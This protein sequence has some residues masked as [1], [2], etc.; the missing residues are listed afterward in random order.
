[1]LIHLRL[2]SSLLDFLDSLGLSVLTSTTS[3]KTKLLFFNK[4]DL[5]AA[6]DYWKF[7]NP[8]KV[9]RVQI[10]FVDSAE[11]VG[12]VRSIAGNSPSLLARTSAHKKALGAVLQTG[13]AHSHRAAAILRIQQMYAIGPQKED[14]IEEG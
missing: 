2:F 4:K 5:Q 3:I 8:I 9:N 14:S 1:M 6:T 7:V 11:P 13:M 10:K 12:L